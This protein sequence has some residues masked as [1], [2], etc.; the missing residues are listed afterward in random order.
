MNLN[1]IAYE[2]EEISNEKKEEISN[3][4]AEDLGIPREE[5]L[6]LLMEN[7]KDFQQLMEKVIAVIEKTSEYPKLT[8][9]LLSI[10][11]KVILDYIHEHDPRETRYIFETL[12]MDEL[13]EGIAMINTKKGLNH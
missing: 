2:K 9:R 3:K 11:A 12:L 10:F 7:E 6:E 5:C 1:K 8:V 4:M 13:E